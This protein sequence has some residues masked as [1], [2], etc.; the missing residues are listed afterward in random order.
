M[1]NALRRLPVTS[2]VDA[3]EAEVGR[4]HRFV[5]S[6]QVQNRAIVADAQRHFGILGLPDASESIE[7]L[8]FGNQDEGSD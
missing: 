8:A 6:G 7:E 4:N 1:S 5:F 3:L 2:E